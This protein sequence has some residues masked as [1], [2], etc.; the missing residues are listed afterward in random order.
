MTAIS[1]FLQTTTGLIVALAALLG[2]VGGL[3]TTVVKLV[4]TR[5]RLAKLE[6]DRGAMTARLDTLERRHKRLA[7]RAT[8]ES[9]VESVRSQF[10]PEPAEAADVDELRAEVADL[11]AQIAANRA[12][13][14]GEVRRMSSAVTSLE[15]TIT[16]LLN[17][18]LKITP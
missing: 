16:H 18:Q 1:T 4:G 11:R 2:A 13:L 5:S 3:I 6:A 14:E 10:L 12:T 8:L 9:K 15:T 7:E 17:G